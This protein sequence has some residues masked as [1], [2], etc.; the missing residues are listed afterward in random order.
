[1]Q[2]EVRTFIEE[3]T[4]VQEEEEIKIDETTFVSCLSENLKEQYVKIGIIK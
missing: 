4:E 1:M 2:I 3:F